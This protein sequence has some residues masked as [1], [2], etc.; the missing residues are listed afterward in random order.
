MSY[1]YDYRFAA[2]RM[3]WLYPDMSPRLAKLMQEASDLSKE[4]HAL[5]Q[6]NRLDRD[7]PADTWR[8]IIAMYGKAI[9][10]W[11]D[12]GVS[13]EDYI[14]D[15]QEGSIRKSETAKDRARKNRQIDR[16]KDAKSMMDKALRREKDESERVEDD[17]DPW[18]RVHD[19]ES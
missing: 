3:Q 4:A 2:N 12:V 17:N 15:F 13:R 8:P 6:N 7:A 5:Y 10:A 14:F 16:Q 11:N 1:S 18:N 19:Y 9:V